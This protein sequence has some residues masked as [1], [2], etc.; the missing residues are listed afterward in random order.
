[1]KNYPIDPEPIVYGAGTSSSKTGFAEAEKGVIPDVIVVEPEEIIQDIPEKK[2][3]RAKW[4][5][6]TAA[7]TALWVF[8]MFF[9]E[10]ETVNFAQ[11][12]ES[13]MAESKL[14]EE[15]ILAELPMT[16]V[17]DTEK[18]W[19][20]EIRALPEL[21][22]RI[23]GRDAI[24]WD[25]KEIPQENIPSPSI[26]EVNYALRD[27]VLT[28]YTSYV[29]HDFSDDHI[30]YEVTEKAAYN[31]QDSYV[32]FTKE[33]SAYTYH[34]N[35]K[36]AEYFYSE[37]MEEDESFRSTDTARKEY[38]GEDTPYVNYINNFTWKLE[39]RY[40]HHG[41]FGMICDWFDEH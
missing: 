40:V 8:L 3:G 33:I 18:D 14:S 36:I 13:Y 25:I 9:A 28:I 4:A 21:Q 22:E 37:E 32:L 30:R 20:R 24:T 12:G 19:F 35:N 29:E 16:E 15:Q 38:F 34:S 41:I 7:L 10:I 6:L 27:G 1:M 17:T 5:V 23:A 11:S 39:T 2:H 31:M 26:N